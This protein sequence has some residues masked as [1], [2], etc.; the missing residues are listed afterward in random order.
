MT[1]LSQTTYIQDVL[2][3]AEVE[4]GQSHLSLARSHRHLSLHVGDVACALWCSGSVRREQYG[5][6]RETG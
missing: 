6:A 4:I 2:Q 3:S 5:N 1:Q